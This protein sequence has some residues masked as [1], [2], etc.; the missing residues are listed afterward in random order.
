MKIVILSAALLLA[1]APAAFAAK[2]PALYIPEIKGAS[3]LHKGWIDLVSVGFGAGDPPSLWQPGV[4]AGH[5][6]PARPGRHAASAGRGRGAGAGKAV[7]HTV[8]VMKSV[9]RTSK[10]LQQCAA[11]L[12]LYHQVQIEMVSPAPMPVRAVYTLS[13]AR[14]T[15]IR[16][17]SARAEVLV[18]SARGLTAREADLPAGTTPKAENGPWNKVNQNSQPG[19]T[20]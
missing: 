12:C 19:R 15:S 16:P 11:N 5:E 7:M 6:S 20:P 1:G 13:D 9:D 4:Q 8:T 18:F 10:A 3:H 14:L 2:P 17:G